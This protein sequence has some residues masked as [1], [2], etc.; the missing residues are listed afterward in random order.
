MGSEDGTILIPGCESGVT[1]EFPDDRRDDEASLDPMMLDNRCP[2]MME[3]A[4]LSSYIDRN[5]YQPSPC[6]MINRSKSRARKIEH[7]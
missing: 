7:H 3:E 4:R 1:V 5:S 6:V 2:E